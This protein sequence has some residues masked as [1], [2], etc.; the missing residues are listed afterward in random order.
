MK[1]FTAILFAIIFV[2]P[3]PLLPQ[4]DITE[5]FNHHPEIYFSFNISSKDEV[6]ILTHIISIDNVTGNTVFAYANEEEF[7]EFLKL[8]YKYAVLTRPSLL[9]TP[10]MSSGI[11]DFMLS[12]DSYPT[13]EMYVSMMTQFAANYPAICQLID[14]GNTVQGRKILFVKI[15]DNINI[16]EPEPQFMF[17][18]T[19]HGDETTGYILML[20]LI[21]SLLTSYGSVPRIT[22]LINNAEIWINPNANPDGTYRTG[23]HTVSGATRSNANNVDLNRNFPDPVAGPHPDGKPWQPETIA[24]M[25]LA[26]TNNFILSSNFHGG[27]EVVNY[28]WDTWAQLHADNNWFIYI[29]RRYADTVH[30]NSSPPYMRGFN[31]GITNGYAWYRITGGRQDYYTYFARGRETTI[32]I[33]N[34]KLLPAS[35]LPA[36][37]NYNK[38]S[39][40]DYIENTLYGIRGI[41]TDTSGNPLKAMISVSGHDFNQSEIF[42]DSI[43][44]FYNRMIMAGTYTLTFSAP[45]HFP[46][47][48]QNVSVANL[49]STE[50]NI[51]LVPD[52][53]P[54]ELISFTAVDAKGIVELNWQTAAE[55]NN[56]GFEIH[57]RARSKQNPISSRQDSEGFWDVIGFVKGKGTSTEIS[58]YTFVDEYVSAGKNYYR[59][60]QIDFDGSYKIYNMI[61]VEVLPVSFSLEQNYP[62]PFN[63]TTTITFYLPYETEVNLTVYD[64][65]GNEISQ[66]L[67]EVMNA[68]KHNIQ[69][70][71]EGLASGIYFYRLFAG[72]NNFVRKMLVVK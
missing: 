45:D 9:V 71:S 34:T 62:N 50:L 63:P 5:Y 36:H 64:V 42:S 28:P 38:K 13:Y 25:N 58:G 32:E 27:A 51:L 31:N 21:D 37:W 56:Y 23:N 20:R 30:A 55:L 59:L 11:E 69:F 15:S 65:L 48:V 8:G 14:A 1:L 44:G 53:I 66:L 60:K 12:W 2:L 70:S 35:Q 4:Q 33:S 29:S 24:M 46:Q 16:R 40:L 6:N 22:N 41:V 61:E 72:G 52:P 10:S 18:S 57:K 54:V 68:G 43:T 7:I 17:S 49:S 19:M 47:T 3:N 26:Q 39:F 67:G